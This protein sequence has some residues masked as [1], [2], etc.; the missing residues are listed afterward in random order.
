[1][2]SEVNMGGSRGGPDPLGKS[3]VAIGFL[4]NSGSDLPL[5]ATGP[6]SNASQ[7]R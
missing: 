3:Q 2:N 7:G 4:R 5:E 6:G 1:M